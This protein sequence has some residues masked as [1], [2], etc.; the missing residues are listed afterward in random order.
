M[1]K[2]KQVWA[3]EI[4]NSRGLPTVEAAMELDTGQVVSASVPSGVSIGKQ[5][6]LELRDNDPQRYKG[7]GV[8]KSV[9]NITQMLGP[10]IVGLDPVKLQDIDRKML[11]LD[12]TPNKSK[13]G[14]NS[15][16]A[17][18]LIS[19]KA[20]ASSLNKRL[21]A[22]INEYAKSLGLNKDFSLPTPLFNLIEGGMHAAHNL[23][24]QEF[25][26]IPASTKSFSQSLKIGVEVYLSVGES[27]INHGAVRSLG[28]EGGYAPNLFKNSDAFE[29]LIESIRNAGY[30][31]GRD[32]F[33]G[34]DAA[35][36]SF[37]KDGAY[38]I[39]DSTAPIDDNAMADYYHRLNNQYKLAIIEDP[40]QEEAWDSWKKLT[41]LI[42]S[43]ALIVGDDLLVTNEQKVKRAI[44]EKA[45]NSAIIKPNQVGTITETIKVMKVL[46]DAS[47]KAVV[48]HRGGETNDSF[49]ADFAVGT[50]AEYI[51]FGAPAR[52]ERV[53]KYNRL[54]GIEAEIRSMQK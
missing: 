34:L 2:I 13:I 38:V 37:F 49:I 19:A 31:L 51:K 29:I 23:D 30:S 20:A 46:D 18:S 54:L 48:S 11:E 33:L 12:G 41:Q 6:A 50:G 44:A 8:L 43:Q 22:F 36:N 45:C 4:I 52:G 16:L 24:F 10:A 3:R 1:S 21:F 26:V 25:H 35:A 27:L 39:K 32:V 15:I 9:Q 14:A 17:V 42:G 28:D 47:W 53:A 7:K 5:E 40:F